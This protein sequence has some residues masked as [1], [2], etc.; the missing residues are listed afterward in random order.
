[1]VTEN[2]YKID[3]TAALENIKRDL[4]DMEEAGIKQ[5]VLDY[6]GGA[7]NEKAFIIA[8]KSYVMGRGY[9]CGHEYDDGDLLLVVRKVA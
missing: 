8:A 2:T 3:I 9:A 7:V 6:F 4:D 5:V 1:M